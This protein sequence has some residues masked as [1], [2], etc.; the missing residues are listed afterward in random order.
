MALVP[1]LLIARVPEIFESVVV[2][3]HV[4]MP[5]LF[6]RTKPGVAPIANLFKLFVLPEYMRSPVVY[7]EKPVPP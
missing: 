5:P 4:G 7:V 6:D 1:P 3:T 2:A